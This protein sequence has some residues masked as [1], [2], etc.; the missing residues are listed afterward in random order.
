MTKI[1]GVGSSHITPLIVR[2]G[3]AFVAAKGKDPEIE[4]AALAE[5]LRSGAEIGEGEREMLAELVTGEWRERPGAKET[6]PG[7]PIVKEVVAALRELVERGEKKEAAKMTVAGKFGISR[8]TVER[9]EKITRERED[10]ISKA[11]E[12]AR[13]DRHS[14]D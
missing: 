11:K 1:P 3:R 5:W 2:A 9:Y 10:A 6:T 4:G 13:A 7:T 14:L 8:A 12:A